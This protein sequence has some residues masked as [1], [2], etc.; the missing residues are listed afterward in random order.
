LSYVSGTSLGKN[1]KSCRIFQNESNKIEFAFFL[2]FYDFLRNLQVSAIHKYYF[3]YQ[4]AV[5]P[6]KRITPL[7]WSSGA[8][9]GAILA[10]AGGG[11]SRGRARGGLGVLPTRFGKV[12]RAER[13]PATVT[14]GALSWWPQEL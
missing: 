1:N 3:N 5:R 11:A 14:G 12:E 13:R 10:R 4:F 9:G 7:Q 8:A 2:F 6:L